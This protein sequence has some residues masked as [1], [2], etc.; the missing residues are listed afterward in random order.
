MFNPSQNSF[1]S[2]VVS[3]R[4]LTVSCSLSFRPLSLPGLRELSFLFVSLTIS[5]SRI[6]VV[7]L[8]A[9][10]DSIAKDPCFVN[11]FFEVI[12]N[13]FPSYY[14]HCFSAC[15]STPFDR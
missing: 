14:M 1:P 7:T 15:F 8:A 4:N 5:F 9:T 6:A 12:F 11:T 10:D 3:L 2:S 13:S